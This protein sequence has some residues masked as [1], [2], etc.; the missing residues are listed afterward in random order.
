M[1]NK[2]KSNGTLIGI[3]IGIIIMLLV[4]VALYTTGNINFKESTK[5]TTKESNTYKVEDYVTKEKVN[6]GDETINVERVVFKNLDSTLTQKY[7]EE[8]AKLIATAETTYD[9]FT[10]R[11]KKEELSGYYIEGG[12]NLA[13]SNI[14]YQ[15]NKDILTVHYELERVEEIGTETLLAVT[16]INLKSKKVMTNEELLK[17]GNSSFNDIATKEY[18]RVLEECTKDVNGKGFCYYDG[19]NRDTYIEVTFEEHKNNK[20]KFISNIESKLDEIIKVYIQDGKI[21]YD[22][23]LL[24]IRL[25]NEAIGTGGPFPHTVVEVGEYK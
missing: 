22:Y 8:Q 7:L 14:W 9:Y 25:V 23:T 10:S 24:S 11:Y 21:K 13:K 5:D 20:E 15:I 1:E 19:K 3:L 6:I 2:K 4:G 12:Q 18:E 17:L 16:N